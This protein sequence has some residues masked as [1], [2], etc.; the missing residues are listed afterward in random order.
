MKGKKHFLLQFLLLILCLPGMPQDRIPDS[1]KAALVVAKEDTAQVDILLN[2]SKYYLNSSA[3]ESIKYS[4]QAL[5]LSKK[6]NFQHGKGMA[7]K[8]AGDAYFILG[9]TTATLENYN[10]A[11][12]VFD[13]AGDLEM[14]N[15]VLNN[16]GNT[17]FVSG[18]HPKALENY[19][20]SLEYEEK[21]KD[22]QGIAS[23]YANIGAVYKEQRATQ[24]KAAG[25]LLVA[26][27]LA[28]EIGDNSTIGAVS[29]NLAEI[30]TDLNKDDSALI[31]LNKSVKAYS[32]TINIPFSLLQIGLFYA[33]KGDYKNAIKYHKQSYQMGRKFDSKPDMAHALK[34]L[35]D[36]YFK[37]GD[38]PAALKAYK[39]TD[40]IAKLIPARKDMS[41]AYA[42]LAAT[43]SRMGNY[44]MAFKYQKLF[45]SMSD[46][47]NNQTLSDKLASLQNGFE[48]VKRQTEINLLTQEKKLR[49][50]ELLRQK[51]AKNALI[52]GLIMVIFIVLLMFRDWRI[53]KKTNKILD[54]QKAEI[55]R[56]LLNI[57]PAEVAGELR[58]TG[59]S[60]P[61]YYESVSVLF[62]DYKGFT[63][64][65][66]SL[67][68]QEIVSELSANFMAFDDVIE[69]YGLEKIKTIGDAY[70]CAGGIPKEDPDH[71]VKIIK[72][73]MEIQQYMKRRNEKRK[74]IGL[75]AWE[76]RIGIN[77]GQT[78]AGVVGNKK[79]AYDIWGSA[80]NIASRM[81]SNS[82][83][84]EINI[85]QATYDL[86]KDKFVCEH[87]GKIFAKNIGEI[88]MYF[89]KSE[90]GK[91]IRSGVDS[92]E[93][94]SAV[95]ND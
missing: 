64:I 40:S 25:Y 37:T 9:N 10:Q 31:F 94:L 23:E 29:G 70:M 22:K 58:T 33:K 45:T 47:L 4:S 38:Y 43:Y 59:R 61:R 5:E 52:G 79:Y 95:S 32:N 91:K 62:T 26:I 19:F 17:Y 24:E 81:E 7:F 72:A 21:V 71:P 63:S 82:E 48:I 65:A 8:R 60:T 34:A 16:I 69:R 11:L 55:E 84:G 54:F 68:P 42:G 20:K 1:L 78:V 66:D 75:P 76:L 77:T 41:D 90:I 18:D 85:S 36:S 30:Y 35:G 56:L 87:R 50:V 46:T 51:F 3:D 93:S 83:P 86:V 49:D 6:L 67:S 74:E 2:L 92:S 15:I 57:L 12:R 14:K 27:M 53:K 73:A 88:D 44:N 39:Q 89:V 80:V 13:S 28:E